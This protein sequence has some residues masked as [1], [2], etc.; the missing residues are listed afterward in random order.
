MLYDNVT[1]I[2]EPLLRGRTEV[3]ETARPEQAREWICT[4]TIMMPG[5]SSAWLMDGNTT[6]DAQQAEV[7]A[8]RLAINIGNGEHDHVC[9]CCANTCQD[10]AL[11]IDVGARSSQLRLQVKERKLTIGEIETLDRRL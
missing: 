8:L 11:E 2:I 7:T 3:T 4:G 6:V 5:A 10:Q 1:T 9:A